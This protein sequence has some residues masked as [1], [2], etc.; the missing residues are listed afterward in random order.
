MLRISQIPLHASRIATKPR[1]NSSAKHSVDSAASAENH[2]FPNVA[3]KNGF[4]RSYAT[5]DSCLQL[6]LRANNDTKG[7]IGG[8]REMILHSNVIPMRKHAFIVHGRDARR[9]A[10]LCVTCG[11]EKRRSP[12]RQGIS[13][14]TTY[15]PRTRIIKPGLRVP[16]PVYSPPMN[17]LLCSAK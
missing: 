10:G 8:G 17:S 7:F 1:G 14:C 15:Q 11:K 2:P 12:Y 16:R 6:S 9:E 13:G 5:C 3:K 4:A